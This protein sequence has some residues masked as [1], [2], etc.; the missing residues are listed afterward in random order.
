MKIF[1]KGK[2]VERGAASPTGPV[3]NRY[4]EYDPVGKPR[5]KKSF[6]LE[7][8]P[9]AGQPSVRIMGSR[10]ALLAGSVPVRATS[11]IQQHH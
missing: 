9:L 7:K 6:S 2:E 3:I 1:R 10:A 5:C 8:G 4:K 11:D